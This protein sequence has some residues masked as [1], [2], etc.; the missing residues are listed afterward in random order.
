MTNYW[1]RD[2]LYRDTAP[3]HFST[4]IYRDYFP[5]IYQVP[6]ATLI[7]LTP[8]SAMT[9]KT[10]AIPS[11]HQDYFAAKVTGPCPVLASGNTTFLYCRAVSV[12]GKCF[13]TIDNFLNTLYKPLLLIWHICFCATCH[14]SHMQKQKSQMPSLLFRNNVQHCKKI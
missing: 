3:V 8:I 13:N 7:A 9:A 14:S 1:L 12:N 2:K 11:L 10:R 4:F 6:T 5:A